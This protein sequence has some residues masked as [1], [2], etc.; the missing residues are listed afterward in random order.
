MARFVATVRF[1]DQGIKSIRETTQRAAAFKTAAKR[2]GVKIVDIYWCLGPF[3][4][5]LLFDAPDSQVATSAMLYL[6]AQGNVKTETAEVF[7]AADVEK[8]LQ[9]IGGK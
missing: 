8:I 2:M 7:S 6:A 3:D 1:T 9:G 5:L 4:G